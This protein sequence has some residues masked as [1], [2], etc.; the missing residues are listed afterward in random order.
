MNGRRDGCTRNPFRCNILSQCPILIP[1]QNLGHQNGNALNELRSVGTPGCD[2]GLAFMRVDLKLVSRPKPTD[3]ESPTAP[4][5]GCRLELLQSIH[6]HS[7][8]R[9]LWVSPDL[10]QF[11]EDSTTTNLQQPETAEEISSP[12]EHESGETEW[13]VLYSETI[14]AEYRLVAD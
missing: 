1:A 10:V 8:R 6:R 4:D 9:S 7:A 11:S 12:H 13:Q 5:R 14:R 2:S 3:V